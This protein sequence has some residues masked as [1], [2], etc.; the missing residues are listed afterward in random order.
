MQIEGKLLNRTSHID[1]KDFVV[2]GI[3]KYSLRYKWTQC[4]SNWRTVFHLLSGC[5][6]LATN[7]NACQSENE[8]NFRLRLLTS[9]KQ[10]CLF[11]DVFSFFFLQIGHL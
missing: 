3:F 4:L 8:K 2:S 9:S 5:L 10:S 11:H 7:V 6:S 1:E